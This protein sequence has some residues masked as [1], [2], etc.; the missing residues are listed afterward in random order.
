MNVMHECY[1]RAND[2]MYVDKYNMVM[3]NKAVNV[4]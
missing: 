1:G 3:M 4:Y 2:K